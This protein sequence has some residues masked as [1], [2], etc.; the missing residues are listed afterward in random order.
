MI[1]RLQRSSLLV[2]LTIEYINSVGAFV[3]P[4]QLCFDSKFQTL[5]NVP[6]T[7]LYNKNEVNEDDNNENSSAKG[8]V[9][10]RKRREV[11]GTWLRK[12]LVVG[13]GYNTV[14]TAAGGGDRSSATAAVVDDAVNGRIVSFQIQNLNGIEG[15]TGDI[16]IQLAP[17]WAP[18]GVARFEVCRR[19]KYVYRCNSMLISAYDL[20]DAR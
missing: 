20:L 17:A 2:I 4:S 12:A 9:R 5:H 18:R 1:S 16:K 8:N 14:S 7:R 3:V 10:E 15:K 19:K 11:V 13:L 6:T